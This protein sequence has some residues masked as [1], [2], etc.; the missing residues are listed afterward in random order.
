LQPNHPTDDM[1]GIAASLLDG[2]LLGSGDAVIGINPASDNVPQVVRL[3]HMLLHEADAPQV[4]VL[5]LA[6]EILGGALP[7]L[8]SEL[9]VRQKQPISRETASTDIR[10]RLRDAAAAE[11]AD[12]LDA[13]LS[14]QVMR[15]LSPGADYRP[16]A[17]RTLLEL[18][19]DSLM[20]IEL[21]NRII[22]HLDVTI[23][24]G[25]LMRG[26]TIRELGDTVLALLPMLDGAAPPDADQASGATRGAPVADDEWEC[27]SL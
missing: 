22:S 19:M 9:A 11:R 5:P 4:A 12:L 20:A 2:L 7:P 14:E 23:A 24:V 26:P 3:L 27:G 18:G 13:M 25:D 1:Q 15:V 10:A 8:L 6:P 21:R 17:D 16:D